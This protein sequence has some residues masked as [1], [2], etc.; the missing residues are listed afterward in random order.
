MIEKCAVC[1]GQKKIMSIG[2]MY[3]LCPECNGLGFKNVKKSNDEKSS[4]ATSKRKKSDVS[5]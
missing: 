4:A 1:F 5:N 2:M 3:K